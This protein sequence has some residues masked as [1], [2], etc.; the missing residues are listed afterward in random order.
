[1][2]RLPLAVVQSLA[3]ASSALAAH[4]LDRKTISELYAYAT[5]NQMTSDAFMRLVIRNG[6]NQVEFDEWVD[7]YYRTEQSEP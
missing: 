1:M 2:S 3:L 6:Y 4:P 7:D 5:T